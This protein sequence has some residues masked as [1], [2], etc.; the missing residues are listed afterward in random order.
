MIPVGVKV[1]KSRLTPS[2]AANDV[3]EV[4]VLASTRPMCLIKLEICPVL[5]KV[6]T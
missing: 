3:E 4:A 1:R 6:S 2:Q 5:N